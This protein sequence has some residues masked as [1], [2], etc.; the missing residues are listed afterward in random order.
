MLGL[1]LRNA[2][3][4]SWSSHEEALLF[5]SSD[6]CSPY[7]LQVESYLEELLMIC[8]RSEEYS[9]FLLEKMKD[10]SDQAV[11]SAANLVNSFKTSTFNLAVQELIGYYITYA[12]SAHGPV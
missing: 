2:R 9:T 3:P 12:I 1:M 8:Q 7:T 5:R 4:S 11:S 6:S 10:E